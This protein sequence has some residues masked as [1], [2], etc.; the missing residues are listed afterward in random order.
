MI[1]R[2][3]VLLLAGEPGIGKT[4]LTEE[5]REHTSSGATMIRGNCYR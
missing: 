3:S 1:N 5:F 4:R 2:G